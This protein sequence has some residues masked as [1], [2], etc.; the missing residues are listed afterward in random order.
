MSSASASSGRSAALNNGWNI[1][2][3]QMWSLATETTHGLD[4]GTE[5]LPAVIDPQY[6]AGFVWTRQYGF[7]VTK[8]FGD[9]IWIGAS[10]EN[11]ETLNPAGSSLPTNLLIGSD[12]NSG[13][14]YNATANYSFN[15]A[16]DLLAKIAFEPGLWAT[17]KLFGIAR[18]FRD[19]IY[20]NMSRRRQLSTVSTTTVTGTPDGAY[21]DTTVGGGIGASGRATLLNKKLTVG[22]KGLWGD[23]TGTLRLF[24]HR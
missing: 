20:P 6:V 11:A 15:L 17:M 7:R 22:L 4:N 21:N 3:G 5:I 1:T 24:D 8:N 18:F 23:G 13:G 9:K 16:P 10:A 14:L 12:G 2:G 19:R